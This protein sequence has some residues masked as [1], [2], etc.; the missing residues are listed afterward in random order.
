[1][2]AQYDWADWSGL[3]LFLLIAFGLPTL[4]YVLMILDIRAY[5]RSL[6][7]ALVVVAQFAGVRPAWARDVVPPAL[8]ALRLQPG[9]SAEEVRAAY[10]RLAEACHPDRGGSRRQFHKLRRQFEEALAYVEHHAP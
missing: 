6:R 8:K 5:L 9:C 4:G 7:G 10:R 2:I 3:V 1:M